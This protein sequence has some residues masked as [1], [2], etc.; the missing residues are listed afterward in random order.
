MA[1]IPAPVPAAPAAIR[2]R[3]R[4]LTRRMLF[5]AAVTGVVLWSVAP[6]LWQLSTS[7]QRDRDLSSVTPHWLPVPGTLEHYRAVFTDYEFS[8]YLVNSVIVT[9]TATAI[10]LA[11]AALATYALARLP[12]PGKGVVLAVVLGLSMFPQI[13]I[14]V[15][16][17]LVLNS[18][19]LLDTYTGLSGSYVGLALPLMIFVLYAHFR[20]LPTQ[21]DEAA[22]IDGAGLLR[23][24]RS[25][26]LPLALPGI[27]A[28]GML[29]FIT[30][31]NEF[32]LA[33]AFTSSP[34][35]QTVPVGIAGFQSQYFVPW[36]DMAAASVVVTLPLV[37]IVVLF[38]RRIVAGITSGAVKE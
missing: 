11:L 36:G 24:L 4:A 21:L 13:S 29:G 19:G 14:V 1:A 2:A 6:F 20:S 10:G 8:K 5:R 30:N 38:Q 15:P 23:T 12:V 3:R 17:Y 32:M 16:L 9:V 7:F 31:W 33:L 22:A 18:L 37:L 35:H 34:E 28:A 25:V 27:A 26:I